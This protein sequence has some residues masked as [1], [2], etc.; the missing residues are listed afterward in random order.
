MYFKILYIHKYN[1]KKIMA[2]IHV[3]RLKALYQN[4]RAAC[5]Y[6]QK[7]T[8]QHDV[9]RRQYR[10]PHGT[11]HAYSYRLTEPYRWQI[12]TEMKTKY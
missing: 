9:K 12:S 5:Y 1:R 6:F 3:R 11:Y 7:S 2:C 4:I 10:W 8:A